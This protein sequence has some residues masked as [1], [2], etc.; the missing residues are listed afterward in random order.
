MHHLPSVEDVHEGNGKDIGLLGAREVRDVGVQG[1]A[2]PWPSANIPQAKFGR[3]R[4]LVGAGIAR[5]RLTFSAAPALAAA[6]LTPRMALAP[7]LVLLG[8]PSRLLRNS[9]TLDWSLTSRPSLI[10]AGPMTVLTFST[11]LVTPLPSHLALSPSRSSHASCWPVVC[12]VVSLGNKASNA[13]TEDSAHQ[14]RRQRGQWR[15]GGR[16]Q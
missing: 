5:R 9:S 11:A 8:V 14:S 3:P 2:L 6:K 12:E 16:S 7:S 13:E 4:P 15:G 10:R 1:N